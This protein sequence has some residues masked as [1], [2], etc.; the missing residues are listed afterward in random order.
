MKKLMNRLPKRVYATVL[1][2]AVLIGLSTSALAGFGPNRPTKAWT[3]GVAGFDHVTFNSFTGVGNGVGDERD[4]VRGVQVGRDSVWS[5]PVQNVTQDAEVEAKI[6]IHNGADGSLNDAPGNPGIARN[7]NV[8][9]ALPTGEKQSQDITSY[10]KASN[11]QPGEVFDTLTLTGANKGNFALEYVA[12]SAKLH[13]NGAATNLTA[14]QEQALISNSG[15]N[16][17]DMPGC[18]DY[19]REVTFRV[20][21]KMPQYGITKQVRFKGQTAADWK[22]SVDAKAGD[23]LEWSIKFRNK[24]GRAHV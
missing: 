23:S 15:M 17:A 13:A 20:K 4:F 14:A 22:D 2:A 8:R 18:F 10:I 16:L 11:A 9:V 21:V 3:S 6:Y 5:D 7:V 12:G 24:I 1:A 19:V